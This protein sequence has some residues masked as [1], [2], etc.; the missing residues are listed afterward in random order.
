MNYVIRHCADSFAALRTFPDAGV[1]VI[2]TDPPYSEHCHA[3]MTSGTL[4]RNAKGKG[5]IPR[6]EMKFEP[7]QSYEFARDM[8]RVSRRW[9][10]SFCTVEDLGRFDLLLGRGAGGL[11]RSGV[12]YKPNSM[13][14]LTGDRPA[15]A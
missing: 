4:I 13:G 6:V 2:L 7:L 12:W 3:N 5:G 10:L 14:Q 9:A 15:A 11:V 8:V 1:D